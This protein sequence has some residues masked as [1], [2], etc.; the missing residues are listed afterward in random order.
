MGI[1]AS[2]S[3]SNLDFTMQTRWILITTLLVGSLFADVAV[4]QSDVRLYPITENAKFG[5]A[6]AKGNVVIQP[7]YDGASSFNDGLA[8]VKVGD[9]K[10]YVNLSGKLVVTPQY[11]E[12]SDFSEGLALVN[13]G[14]AWGYIDTTG[15]EVIP[16]QFVEALPFSDGLA[17]VRTQ[18]T[19]SKR[20]AEWGYIDKKGIRVISPKFFKA[21]SFNEGIASVMTGKFGGEN[22][23]G[24]IDKQGKFTIT[25]RYGGTGELS[26][27]LIP[28]E[29]GAKSKKF[30]ERLHS[31]LSGKWGF[32]DSTG[33]VVIQPTFE[34]AFEFSEGLAYVRIGEKYGYIDKSGKTVISP[35]FEYSSDTYR[36]ASF[37]E[38]RACFERDGKIGFIDTTGKVV[39]EPKYEL[40][41]PF[42]DGIA[43]ANFGA[44]PETET[45]R[46]R[47]SDNYGLI[48]LSGK[49][50]YRPSNKPSGPAYKAEPVDP[51]LYKDWKKIEEGMFSFYGPKNLKGGRKQ[52]IDTEVFR[53]ET[54]DLVVSFDIGFLAGVPRFEGNLLP[55]EVDIDGHKAFIWY[56]TYESEKGKRFLGRLY[57]ALGE[58]IAKTP[59]HMIVTSTD[60]NFKDVAEKMF[61]SL[62]FNRKK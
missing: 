1:L 27:G 49:I 5:F 42:S 11:E 38:G 43:R 50:V 24:F 30:G 52:G 47:L 17:A 28:L 35:Q 16:V 19:E 53:Y 32:V 40:V 21:S 60:P 61:R 29:I 18:P 6:D 59:F 36:C 22:K 58:N 4:A 14:F 56:P 31:H 62:R 15:E 37:V 20:D 9:K 12:A 51:A 48:D 54:A 39:I 7:Q 33:K 3:R 2:I 8:M 25:P 41:Y 10:G 34:S 26:E 55:N 44:Y 13:N 46:F 45:E 23:Q 57:V